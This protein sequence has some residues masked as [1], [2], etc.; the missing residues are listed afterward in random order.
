MLLAIIT[1]HPIQYYAPVFKL[2]HQRQQISIKVFYTWGERAGKKYDPGFNKEIEWDIPLLEG[3]PF[4]W[5]TN[6]SEQPGS[7]GFK[8]IVNPDLNQKLK[9]LNPDAILVLGWAYNSHLKVLRYFSNKI[10]VYFRGDSTLLDARKNAKSIVKSLFLKWV[11]SHVDHAFYVG[12]NNKAYFKNYG[13]K[14]DQLTFAPHAI[15]NERFG[16]D[17]GAEA[18][19]LRNNLGLSPTD[20]LIIFAGKF[21]EKKYPLLL[22]NAFLQLGQKNCHLLFVGNGALE[23]ELKSKCHTEPNIHFKDV[24]NQSYMPVIDQ[25]CDLFCLPS[26]GPDETWGLAVN[27]AMASGRAVLVSDKVG[28]AIDLVT[29]NENGAIFRTGDVTDLLQ[30]LKA[31]TEYR[32][33]LNS[34]GINSLRRIKDWNFANIAIAIET[35]LLNEK[36]RQD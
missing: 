24:Q 7:H 2:L 18:S 9:Q 8:G 22:A 20:L 32:E 25:A 12:T 13:L 14:E 5:V 35:Q 4:E 17:R 3:Y 34:Y 16:I 31:L 11:Y 23:A 30:K 1:T 10:P 29:D 36:K 28:C 15:D 21:E 6:T 33:K 26:K 19:E 27:E